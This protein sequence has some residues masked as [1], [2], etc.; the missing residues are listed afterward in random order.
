MTSNLEFHGR[1]ILEAIAQWERENGTVCGILPTEHASLVKVIE[2]ACLGIHTS[3]RGAVEADPI[4]LYSDQCGFTYMD[5]PDHVLLQDGRK[6]VVLVSTIF[7][8]G[9]DVGPENPEA[10]CFNI[11]TAHA[12]V[13][14]RFGGGVN[15]VQR[16]DPDSPL[17]SYRWFV[18]GEEMDLTI[19]LT[20]IDLVE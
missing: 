2:R 18:D 8:D 16:T 12:F 19:W 14:T 9:E 3:A 13:A 7:D 11:E 15:V 20:L 6:Q 17:S 10:I 5:F 1:P 4:T